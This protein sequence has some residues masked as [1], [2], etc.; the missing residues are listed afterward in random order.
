MGLLQFKDGNPFA[1][2][3]LSYAYRPI[4]FYFGTL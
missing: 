4:K 2:G 1:S 3:I